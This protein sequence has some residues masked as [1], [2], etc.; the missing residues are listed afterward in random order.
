LPHCHGQQVVAKKNNRIVTNLTSLMQ[1]RF[2]QESFA[3]ETSTP[4][5]SSAKP[6]NRRNPEG[7]RNY[8]GQKEGKTEL[9]SQAKETSMAI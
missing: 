8:Y 3:N 5:A 6:S 1:R 2:H 4:P 7:T 9:K